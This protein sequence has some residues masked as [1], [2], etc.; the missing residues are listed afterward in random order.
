MHVGDY[1]N[2][3]LVWRISGGLHIGFQ[4]SQTIFPATGAKPGIK[5]D[6]FGPHID[7]NG[8]KTVDGF[9]FWQK[10]CLH[11]LGDR[12]GRLVCAEGR[13]RTIAWPQSVK[14]CGDLKISELEAL[15]ARSL[16]I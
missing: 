12:L 5:K 13:M 6:Q 15:E 16:G 11:E 7:Q 3:D 2:A 14:Q 10:V 1:D 4:L 9:C 8:R